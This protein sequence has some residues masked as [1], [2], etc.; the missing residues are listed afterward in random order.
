MVA[1]IPNNFFKVWTP[2]MAY[3]LGY[4]WADGNMLRTAAGKRVGFTSKDGEQETG[5]PVPTSF[6]NENIWRVTWS[7]MY[8][9]CLTS[10]LYENCTICLERKRKV[11]VEF[12][13]WQPKLYRKSHI[14]LKMRELFGC[15]LPEEH[16]RPL[17]E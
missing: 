5:I 17:L 2:Q 7:G 15:L 10:W 4:W 1:K 13:H 6:A 8:A 11:A 14:T 16:L 3:V 9:K 12:L